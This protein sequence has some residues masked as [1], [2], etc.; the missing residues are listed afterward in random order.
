M[1]VVI[2]WYFISK[3]AVIGQLTEPS[4]TKPNQTKPNQTKPNQT[5]TMVDDFLISESETLAL[6]FAW[7]AL[8][9]A[10]P[11]DCFRNSKEVCLVSVHTHLSPFVVNLQSGAANLAKFGIKPP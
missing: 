7:A 10:A 8:R 6:G 2:G 4:Q 11:D 5:N 9:P 3:D 1:S